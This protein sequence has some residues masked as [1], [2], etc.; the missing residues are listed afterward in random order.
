MRLIAT[1][2]LLAIPAVA[3][4]AVTVTT[5]D[6]QRFTDASDRAHDVDRVVNELK[7]H[8][9]SLGERY[10]PGK[11]V[12]IEVLDVDL[13]GDPRRNPHDLRVMTGRADQPCIE[14]NIAVSGAA[15]SRERICDS[16]YMRSL[17]AR[18]HAD[19]FLVFEKRML[20]NWFKD[21]FR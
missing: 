15:P 16:W 8:L 10:L 1:L 4:A 21:R 11:D 14:M 6:P 12:R 2:C 20:D 18:Y 9:A 3:T 7:Q 5:T 13:A 19:Q 17:G